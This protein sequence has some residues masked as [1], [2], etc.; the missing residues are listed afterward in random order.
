MQITQFS[1][2]AS[3]VYWENFRLQLHI[4]MIL[5]YSTCHIL[6]HYL[7]GLCQYVKQQKPL[8]MPPLNHWKS[9]KTFIQDKLKTSSDVSKQTAKSPGR[10]KSGLV[11]RYRHKQCYSQ[12]IPVYYNNMMYSRHPNVEERTA[13]VCK[14]KEV[15]ETVSYTHRI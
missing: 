12:C 15:E 1:W 10:K 11:L 2:I 8:P 7:R 9:K 6:M 13:I 4:K 5:C 14:L 3:R